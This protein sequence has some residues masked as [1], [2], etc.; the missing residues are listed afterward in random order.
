MQIIHRTQSE[1]AQ[2]GGLILE[3]ALEEE[4]V[5]VLCSEELGMSDSDII[6]SLIIHLLVR[7]RD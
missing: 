4:K 5:Y 6:N 7:S 1:N 3:R 2:G